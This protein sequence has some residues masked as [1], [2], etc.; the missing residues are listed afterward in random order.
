MWC[1]PRNPS[2]H[3]TGGR[4]TQ[5]MD[6]DQIV[7]ILRRAMPD[8]R[9][10]FGVRSL[11]LFGSVARGEDRPGSDIDIL[12][13]FEPGAHV[14]LFTLARILRLLSERLGRTVDLI[15][16]HSGLSESFLTAVDR[17]LLRV[18]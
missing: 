6:R 8:V 15:E 10:D 14:T 18:A 16:R 11:A 7:D 13:E 4:Y 17:D 5:S 3:L 9:R 12:V 1:A 2:G